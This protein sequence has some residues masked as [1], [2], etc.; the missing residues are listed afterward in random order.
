MAANFSVKQ[1]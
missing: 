1:D